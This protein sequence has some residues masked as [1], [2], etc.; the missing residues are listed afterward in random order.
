[1]TC[2]PMSLVQEGED[3]VFESINLEEIV[4]EQAEEL[5]GL[6]LLA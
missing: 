1:M 2:F 6:D 5:V 4:L 3:E